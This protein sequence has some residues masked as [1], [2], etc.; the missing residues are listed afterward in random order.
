MISFSFQQNTKKN[1]EVSDVNS[2]A[3]AVR[4]QWR[5]LFSLK[6]L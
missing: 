6:Q 4:K 2:I 1:T 5:K 3:V